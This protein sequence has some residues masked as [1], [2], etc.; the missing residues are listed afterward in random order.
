M[1]AVEM[2]PCM[3]VSQ[4]RSLSLAAHPSPVRPQPGG[5][6]AQRGWGRPTSPR[7]LPGPAPLHFS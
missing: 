5:S 7:K 2:N 1:Q 4:K 6:A 3:K